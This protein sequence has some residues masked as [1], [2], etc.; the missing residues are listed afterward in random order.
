M[1][2]IEELMQY[3]Q[4]VKFTMEKVRQHNDLTSHDEEMLRQQIERAEE[5]LEDKA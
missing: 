2:Q 5:L 4:S 1:P 3:I